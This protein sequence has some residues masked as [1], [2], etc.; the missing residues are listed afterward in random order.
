MPNVLVVCT[1]NQCRSPV[2]EALLRRYLGEIA[3]DKEWQVAS[4]GTWA[5]AGVPADATMT[6]VAAEWDLDLSGHRS[7]PVS[8][9]LLEWADLVLTMETGQQEA[10]RQEFPSG[11]TQIRCFTELLGVRYDVPDPIGGPPAAYRAAVR[12]L[13]RMVEQGA[14]RIP[15]WLGYGPAS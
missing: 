6:T 15:E 2:A 10:L 8:A 4:A 12:E 9:A 5:R 7:Q 3:P 13:V 11:Q 14:S 1:A